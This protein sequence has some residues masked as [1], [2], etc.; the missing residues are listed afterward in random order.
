MAWRRQTLSESQSGLS[1]QSPS[2]LVGEVFT[3]QQADHFSQHCANTRFTTGGI[4][5]KNCR[6]YAKSTQYPKP[7]FTTSY[8]A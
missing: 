6:H 2:M 1:L 4:T 7:I 5:A 3:F 8:D